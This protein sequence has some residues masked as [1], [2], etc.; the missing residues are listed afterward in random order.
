MNNT[1]NNV[2]QLKLNTWNFYLYYK[3]LYIVNKRKT[4]IIS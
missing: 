1:N 4:S 2:K 3:T